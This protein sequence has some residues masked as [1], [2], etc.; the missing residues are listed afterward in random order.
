MVLDNWMVVLA[1]AA[2]PGFRVEV[3]M[4]VTLLPSGMSEGAV[5]VVEPPLAVCVGLNEPQAPVLPQVAV[6]STPSLR[7]SLVTVA[8]TEAVA[9]AGKASGGAVDIVTVIVLGLTE[10]HPDR[11][12]MTAVQVS[13]RMSLLIVITGLPSQS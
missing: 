11:A 7:E 10:L 12:K 3:A 5:K 4:M 6:Q 8:A 1:V 9:P 2:L 13:R